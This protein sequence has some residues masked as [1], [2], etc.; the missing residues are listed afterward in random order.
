MS[1][2]KC[3]AKNIFFGYVSSIISLL[4]GFI[5]RTIFIKILSTTYLGV[6]GLFINV[7]G[8]LSFAEL[9]IGT[10]MNY[11]LYKPV[12]EKDIEKL[13]SLMDFYKI[14]YRV[15]A[16]VVTII[17]LTLLPFLKYIV[18]DPGNV[19]NISVYYLIFLFNTVTSYFVS[20]K[21]SLVNA[22]QKNYIFSN[23]NTITS[24]V[25]VIMQIITLILFKNF[26]Y[27]LLVAAV[28]GLIQKIFIN[29]YL[30]KKYPY[31]LDKNTKKITKE[32]LKPIKT[33]V[34]ALIWHKIG[35]ISIYQ[36]DNIV[37]STFINVTTVGI[38]SNYNLLITSVSTFITIIFNSAIASLGNLMATEDVS[39]QYNTFKVYR[40]AAFW[41]YGFSSIAFYILL[42]PFITLWIG[43]EMIISDFTVLLIMINYYMVGH[44][45]CINNIK[46]AGGIFDQDKYV[47]L[48]QGVVNL[49]VSI[50]MV[51]LIGLPGVYIGTI[52][53]GILAT[54]IKPIIVYKYAFQK[55]V[56]Y[57]FID[58]LKFASA[59]TFSLV[60]CWIIKY[61]I[62]KNVT[63]FN[64]I[65]MMVVVTLVPNFLFLL[66]FRKNDE[67]IYIKN[68]ILSKISRR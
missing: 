8:V 20:Y 46:S 52:M 40:F 10:A 13:K 32:E 25:T 26:L 41:L 7:L 15:I 33:N 17:G 6:N 1:R 35:E 58:G 30:N 34:I 62:I 42:S 66:F 54:V 60:I 23:I 24:F 45:I 36:T 31:L 12:A 56:R 5:S 67:F 3:T 2:L 4:L 68:I 64:F 53:S 38:I 50:I 49:V 18:K 37:I 57:Y 43:S 51:K 28:I 22:E 44:R 21:F 59:V 65:V 48:L 27:Y 19:G 9:G 29:R 14:A 39:K 47:A 61:N 11:S 55:D 16:L 63:M